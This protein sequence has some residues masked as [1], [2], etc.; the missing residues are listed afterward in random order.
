MTT[1]YPS[2][3]AP[4]R[5]ARIFEKLL[6]GASI[7]L[8]AS[9][10]LIGRLGLADSFTEQAIALGSPRLPAPPDATVQMR[11]QYFSFGAYTFA[12]T[13][14][15]HELILQQG[16]GSL[17]ERISQMLPGAPEPARD[18]LEGMI[19]A[20]EAVC[21]WIERHRARARREAEAATG[22][23]RAR[24]E[25]I[26]EACGQ[27]GRQAAQSFHGALQSI[28]FMRLAIG[29]SERCH[30]SL[31]LGRL[32]QDLL[33]FYRQ[34]L[35]RGVPTGE[36]E[37]LL[38]NFLVAL[39]E[40][41]DPASALN[42]G[43]VDADGGDQWNELSDLIVR[44]AVRL[45]LPSPLLAV[46]IHPRM[47]PEVLNAVT[48][49]A[50]LQMGQPTYYG[51]FPCREALR[52]RGVPEADLPRWT[53]NSC[54]GLMMPG[55]EISD[56]WAAVVNAPLALEL[57]TNDGA[58]YLGGLPIAFDAPMSLAPTDFG[59]LRACFLSYLDAMLE[60]AIAHN[61]AETAWIAENWPNSFLSALTADCV[62]RGLDRAGGGARYHVVTVE[63]MGLVNAADALTAIRRLVYEQRQ[64]T[65][66]ELVAAACDDFAGR[67]DLRQELLAQP[68]FGNG[69]AE[70][71]ALLRELAE[72]F[73]ARV[74]E[75]SAGNR[76]YG[77]SFHTLNA[78]I[79]AGL[80]LGASL[81]GRRAGKPLAKNVGTT[82]GLVREGPTQLMLSATAFDQRD[83]FGGQALDLSL[84]ASSLR[85]PE[86]RRKFQALL[87][88][89]FE[90]GGLEVQV[91][92]LTADDL[93][94]AIADPG[95][96]RDLTVRIAGYSA[97]FIGLSP[98]V[99][100]E[101]VERLDAGL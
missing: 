15:N 69:N 91:N 26:A 18:T 97:R 7:E 42:L 71:D 55:E 62:E 99:Q 52:R 86:D 6:Y 93:R 77:P 14:I 9:G 76:L 53:A 33:P 80:G 54:M 10:R 51:E 96:H 58:P 85:A 95:A 12:H 79:S 72:H 48:Q 24:L 16:L 13:T 1:D 87:M 65:L 5:E 2:L 50:L 8:P 75:H 88:T 92:G 90:R 98:T 27:S 84:P 101:M 67:E 23:E 32:D 57:A 29:V 59:S 35:A 49:P 11:G 73:A 34:D 46:H 17:V 20:L 31:S 3:S 83:F 94:A 43:G 78:H 70:A 28:L 68:K 19:I 60:W 66:A 47:A 56:M 41:G 45:Q 100:Q 61:A 74:A 4:I 40:F 37:E 82:P 22:E 81:D 36:L 39:N 30:A 63:V 89:Y 38:A 44:T 21:D 25:S 64:Y